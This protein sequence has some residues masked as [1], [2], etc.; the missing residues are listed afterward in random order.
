MEES[1]VLLNAIYISIN[2]R[3]WNE[4]MKN[5]IIKNWLMME[6]SLTIFYCR[7]IRVYKLSL[8]KLYAKRWFTCWKSNVTLVHLCIR[9]KMNKYIVKSHDD[10]YKSLHESTK[11]ANVCV[12]SQNFQ[13]TRSQKK[14]DVY[15]CLTYR[16]IAHNSYF[17]LLGRH[18]V[19]FTN[20]K[21]AR[22]FSG[23]WCIIRLKPANK[24]RH[25]DCAGVSS[26]L[27]YSE[28]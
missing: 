12:V 18:V 20:W 14:G 16:S 5:E 17:P 15:V 1:I 6:I 19:A 11:H 27:R 25:C 7:V 9:E 10:G 3:L 8:D 13:V 28:S 22:L 21:A 24:R 4:I 2:Y 23:S 26:S